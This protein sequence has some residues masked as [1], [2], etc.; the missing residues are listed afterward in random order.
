MKQDDRKWCWAASADDETWHGPHD[1]REAAIAE[2]D[3]ELDDAYVEFAVSRCN[4]ADPADAAERWAENFEPLTELND[5]TD[6][7]LQD[8]EDG[9]TYSYVSGASDDVRANRELTEAVVAWARKNIKTR[10]FC[11]DGESVEVIE[12]GDARGASKASPPV[13]TESR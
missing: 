3:A 9:D 6:E 7:E 12:R 11:C 8:Y 13:D 4:H 10:W 5:N 1:T 2:A